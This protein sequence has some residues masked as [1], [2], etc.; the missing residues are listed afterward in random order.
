MTVA[1][2]ADI[3]ALRQLV[4]DN[5][6]EPKVTVVLEAAQRAVEGVV[7]MPFNAAAALTATM[8]GR[9]DKLLTLPRWPVS[10][11]TTVTVDG[12]V[13]AEGTDYVVDP[14]G[15]LERLPLGGLW[16][17]EPR[18]I[19]VVYDAGWADETK[20][21]TGLRQ[22]V[23]QIATR[24]WQAGIAFAETDGPAGM[25]QETIGAY[26]A[27]YGDFATDGSFGITLTEA[28]EATAQQ[29]KRSRTRSVHT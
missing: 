7:G 27:T 1:A 26:S 2:Q 23:A 21:P 13:E 5:Q 28:E 3:E 4:F 29:F 22:L 9:G 15:Y 25:V 20:A 17:S 10:T 18:G 14:A 6:P 11:V 16:W 8:T 24:V 19:V 12:V